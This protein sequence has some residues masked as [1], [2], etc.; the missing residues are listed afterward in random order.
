MTSAANCFVSDVDTLFKEEFLHIPEAQAKPKVEPDSM[1]D[2]HCWEAVTVVEVR[3]FAHSFSLSRDEHLV[4]VTVPLRLF[5][6]FWQDWIN[7]SNQ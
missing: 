2:D 4:N 3:R 5:L 1:A 7:S 6:C